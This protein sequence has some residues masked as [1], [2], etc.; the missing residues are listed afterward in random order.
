MARP[1]GRPPLIYILWGSRSRRLIF[2]SS[3]V[4][5]IILIQL[6]WKSPPPPFPKYTQRPSVGRC[7]EAYKYTSTL[8]SSTSGREVVGFLPLDQA[9]ALCSSH[10]LQT[11]KD[12]SRPRKVYDLFL[13]NTEFDWLEIRLKELSPYVDHF[14]LLEALETFSGN[15]KPLYFKDNYE[16][17]KDLA[18]DKLVYHALDM[19]DMSFWRGSW[20]REE[21]ARNAMF[22]KVFPSL[23]SPAIPNYKDVILVSDIDEIPRPETIEVLRNC[24]FPKRTNIRSRFFYYSYQWQHHGPDWEHPQATWYDG[25]NDTILPNDL[26]WNWKKAEWDFQNASWHCSS[27]F[28]TVAEMDYKIASFSHQ[29]FNKEKFRDPAQI[30]RRV[31][32]GIDLFDRPSEKYDRQDPVTDVPDFLL[33]PENAE[34]FKFM[35][36]RDP[37]NANFIDY[38]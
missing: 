8:N 36:D 10:G 16:C 3:I 32:N 30:V 24:E 21:Y 19:S 15:H 33:H 31:R 2:L 18:P 27:C 17:L 4:I 38:P 13:F 37:P 12:R 20:A 7:Q 1:L 35:L 25:L 34:R 11:F 6:L 29:E 23:L 22:T 28:S 14:I 9:E 5:F 26:R